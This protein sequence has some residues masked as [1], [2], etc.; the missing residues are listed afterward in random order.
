MCNLPRSICGASLITFVVVLV[1]YMVGAL[2]LSFSVVIIL[3]GGLKT[4]HPLLRALLGALELF[5]HCIVG[6]GCSQGGSSS[7]TGSQESLGILKLAK[8]GT[9]SGAS[10][11]YKDFWGASFD[12]EREA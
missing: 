1:T 5:V 3:A 6:V 2:G 7:L 8:P 12:P 10:Q 4:G 9:Q 11:G